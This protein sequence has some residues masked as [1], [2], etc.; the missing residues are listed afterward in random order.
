[1]FVAAYLD[2]LLANRLN[3]TLLTLFIICFVFI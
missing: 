1:M 3:K 2:I